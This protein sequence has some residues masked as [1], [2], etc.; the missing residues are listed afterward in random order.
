MDGHFAAS[1][2]GLDVARIRE[3]FPILAQTVRGKPL[4]FLDSAASAQKPRQVVSAMVRCMETAY[5]NVHRGPYYLSEQA[6]DA[7]E[8]ARAAVARFL[9]LFQELPGRVVGANAVE[10][11]L[12]VVTS[13]RASSLMPGAHAVV[14]FRASAVEVTAVESEG[15]VPALVVGAR[16]RAQGVSVALRV[17]VRSP[18]GVA[19]D[20]AVPEQGA[21]PLVGARV[22]IRL[23]ASRALVFPR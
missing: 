6:T 22:G 12:G 9:G 21:M 8:A 19:L 20:A 15:A 4:V 1:D 16:H 18:E 14:A 11:A 5:A 3:D 7:Y 2:A 17:D 13:E 23:D 10:C